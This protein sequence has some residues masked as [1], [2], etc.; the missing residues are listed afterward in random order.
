MISGKLSSYPDVKTPSASTDTVA[1]TS[2]AMMGLK[3][4]NTG[5]VGSGSLYVTR[6]LSLVVE[7][8]SVDAA[9]KQCSA[10]SRDLYVEPRL[11]IVGYLLTEARLG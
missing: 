3:M 10:L 5:T 1:P 4:R 9:S 2:S 6:F 8:A 7:V 11:L